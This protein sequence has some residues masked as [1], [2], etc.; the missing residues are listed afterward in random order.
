MLFGPSNDRRDQIQTSRL[1]KPIP[2]GKQDI[3]RSGLWCQ[4]Y[5]TDNVG[6]T[7]H[8]GTEDPS[9]YTF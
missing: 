6:V 7:I 3:L 9:A 8:W 4:Y 1:L 2:A 5:C